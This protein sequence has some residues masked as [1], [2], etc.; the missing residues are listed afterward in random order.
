VPLTPDP[1]AVPVATADHPFA[2]GFE[3]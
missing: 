3:A 2:I 1:P